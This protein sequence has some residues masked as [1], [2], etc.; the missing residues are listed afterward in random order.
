MFLANVT[1]GVNDGSSEALMDSKYIDDL[2]HIM[3]YFDK[4]TKNRFIDAK[5]SQYIEFGDNDAIVCS[6]STVCSHDFF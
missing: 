6:E 2:D 3:G 4:T 5:E 1:L